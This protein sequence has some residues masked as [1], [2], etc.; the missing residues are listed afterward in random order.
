MILQKVWRQQHPRSRRALQHLWHVYLLYGRNDRTES[1][2]NE[3]RR[4]YPDDLYPHIRRINELSCRRG[5]NGEQQEWD[6]IIGLAATAP[7]HRVSVLSVFKN[8]LED[9]LTGTCRIPDPRRYA[10]LLDAISQNERA[11]DD[12]GKLYKFAAVFSVL[13]GDRTGALGYINR[14]IN[15]TPSINNRIFKIRLL[16]GLGMTDQ[17][18]QLKHMVEQELASDYRKQLRYKKMLDDIVFETF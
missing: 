17:A 9:H 18:K 10:A 7:Y 12:R 5:V 15:Y 3:Y 6:R 2:Y 14:A 8:A 13:S 4:L 16:H 1:V 11:R